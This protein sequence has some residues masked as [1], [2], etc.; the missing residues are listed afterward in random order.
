MQFLQEKAIVSKRDPEKHAVKAMPTL[1]LCINRNSSNNCEPCFNHTFDHPVHANDPDYFSPRAPLDDDSTCSMTQ[2]GWQPGEH[3]PPT[4]LARWLIK[5][6][7]VARPTILH[8]A[9]RIIR[10]DPR[11]LAFVSYALLHVITMK[12]AFTRVVSQSLTNQSWRIAQLFST[13]A[14]FCF[15]IRW[16]FDVP[17]CWIKQTIVSHSMWF[18]SAYLVSKIC[19][20]T[21]LA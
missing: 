14:T 18:D 5:V 4:P 3:Q 8:P 1:E 11:N 13:S 10:W 17:N 7:A 12:S 2:N 15:T 19:V 21:P 16:L 9:T 20:S 6:V